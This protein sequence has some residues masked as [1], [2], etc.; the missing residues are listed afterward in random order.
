MNYELSVC[1]D[2]FVDLF[3]AQ[4]SQNNIWTKMDLGVEKNN[5]TFCPALLRELYGI[6]NQSW[7]P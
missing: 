7:A 4:T 2:F 1:F 6:T 3:Y 5:K